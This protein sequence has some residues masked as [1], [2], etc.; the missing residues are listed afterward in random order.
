[1]ASQ[2]VEARIGCKILNTMTELGM[3]CSEMIG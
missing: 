1:L 3:P 2:R